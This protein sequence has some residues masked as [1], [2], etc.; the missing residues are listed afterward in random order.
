[1]NNITIKTIG[2]YALLL[3]ILYGISILLNYLIKYYADS[4]SDYNLKS[5]ILIIPAG[6]LV[7]LNIITAV[8][9][10][11]DMQKLEVNAKYA[12]LL[13]IFYRPIGVLLF[14]LYVINKELNEKPAHNDVSM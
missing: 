1:M 8:V 12:V 11:N 10:Y 4:I 13:T 3:S 9:I 5:I 7:L 2:K 6:I 14:L